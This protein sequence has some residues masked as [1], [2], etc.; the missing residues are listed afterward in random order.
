MGFASSLRQERHD[1]W[2]EMRLGVLVLSGS[3]AVGACGSRPVPDELLPH[4][5]NTH[6]WHSHGVHRV[7]GDGL[8]ELVMEPIPHETRKTCKKARRNSDQ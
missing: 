8:H 2:G 7:G 5:D 4:C 1:H 3:V 6:L